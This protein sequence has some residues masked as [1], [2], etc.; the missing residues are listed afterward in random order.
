MTRKEILL[1][2][3]LIALSKAIVYSIPPHIQPEN[4]EVF[5]EVNPSSIIFHDF[6]QIF[7]YLFYFI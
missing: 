7:I 4:S 2:G 6:F 1:A 5:A 3:D